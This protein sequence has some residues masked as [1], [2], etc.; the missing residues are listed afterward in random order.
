MIWFCFLNSRTELRNTIR[1][2]LINP[3]CGGK[4]VS[5]KG[6]RD[7]GVVAFA[8]D[9]AVAGPGVL[10]EFVEVLHEFCP[11]G[12]KVDIADQFEEIRVFFADDGL[13]SVL[14]EVACAF[15]PFVEGDGASP[16]R[17]VWG[18][19]AE[20]G[21]NMVRNQGPGVTLCFGL[22]QDNGEAV[23]EGLAI[24]VIEEELAAFDA[25]GHDVL[26]EAGGV[27]SGLAE[28]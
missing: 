12:V 23:E 18:R 26:E 6:L 9:G 27:K 13:V 5:C 7:E 17:G 11:H 15:V 16:C 21:E 28:H 8:E 22:F 1:R 3:P 24:C 14:E 19:C 10:V 2:R 25:S 20:G 4:R